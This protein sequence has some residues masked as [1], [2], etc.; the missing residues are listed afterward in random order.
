MFNLIKRFFCDHVWMSLWSEEEGKHITEYIC[1][2]C[3]KEHKLVIEFEP[4]ENYYDND[5]NYYADGEQ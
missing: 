1:A 5:E 3:G 4:D 2:K